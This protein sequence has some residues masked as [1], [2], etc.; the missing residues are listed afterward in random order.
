PVPVIPQEK[1]APKP[2]PKPPEKSVY[3]GTSPNIDDILNAPDR[4]STDSAKST[5][6]SRTNT[7]ASR[8]KSEI[9]QTDSIDD[10]IKLLEKKKGDL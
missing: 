9:A 8:T 5:S 6:N 4:K 2:V 1:K 3:R 7:V 10:L